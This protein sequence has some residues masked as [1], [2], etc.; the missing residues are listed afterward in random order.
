MFLDTALITAPADGIAFVAKNRLRFQAP[1]IPGEYRVDYRVLDSFGETAAAT[2]IFTVTPLDE[3]ANRDPVPD[4]LVGR[5]LAGGS[6]RID[7]PLNG[8]DPDGD[9]TQLLNF[10]RNPTL[11][12][13]KEVGNDFFIYE[14]SEAAV[15][16]DE[17]SYRVYDAFGATG[18]ATVKIAVIPKP[19]ELQPPN[20][21]P[22]SVSVRPGR[23]AQVDLMA[24]DSDPQG[25]PIKVSKEL[26]DVPAGID[27]E[28]VGRQYLVITAPKTEQSFSLRY[29]LTNN[30]GGKTM[31]YVLVTVTPDAPLLPP[32]A[33]DVPIL[34][35]DIAGKK[36]ITVNIFD[37][38]AFNPS[39]KT[40]DLV[41]SL[42]G[43][44]AAA[45][46]LLERNGQIEI[47]PGPTRQA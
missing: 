44:N 45:A 46:T 32:S 21:A 13:L 31:S 33:D 7:V 12:S 16:T 23:I 3:E 14:S 47:T 42:D 2:A 6:I 39:G 28:V 9:S 43:P 4:P 19:S 41:V 38:Y 10:P 20:A 24:N 36:N 1:A 34:T 40:K 37:G 35:K 11:G 29:E 27:A 25:S 15:G 26:I 5:V 22:D 8:V 30:R 17:F 18:E